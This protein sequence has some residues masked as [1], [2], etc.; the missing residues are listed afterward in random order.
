MMYFGL[1][2]IGIVL[3]ILILTDGSSSIGGVIEP[4]Q[5]AG[6]AWAA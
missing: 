5:L 4:D 6:L 2:V 1:I 3:A